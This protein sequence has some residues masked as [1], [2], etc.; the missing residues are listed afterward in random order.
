MKM[1][2]IFPEID[3]SPFCQHF[4]TVPIHDQFSVYVLL[5][6]VIYPHVLSP[7]RFQII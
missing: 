1:I 6:R 5:H 7:S 2:R 3:T 4:F